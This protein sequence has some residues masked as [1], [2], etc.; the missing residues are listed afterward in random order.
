MGNPWWCI[1]TTWYRLGDVPPPKTGTYYCGAFHGVAYLEIA[2]R[3]PHVSTDGILVPAPLAT[4]AF[5]VYFHFYGNLWLHMWP[6]H[7]WRAMES[8]VQSNLLPEELEHRLFVNFLSACIIQTVVRC[9]T[10][11][12]FHSF[13]TVLCIPV[14]DGWQSVAL[15]VF[16]TG[17][18]GQSGA[19]NFSLPSIPVRDVCQSFALELFPSGF[20]GQSGAPNFSL[21][22]IRWGWMIRG[23]IDKILEK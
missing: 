14:G 4:F 15:E 18:C 11:D 8:S 23:S 16:P 19:P 21:S 20:C 5:S 6:V 7:R 13:A 9:P 12:V 22:Y 1:P 17:V 2:Q 10:A 3:C